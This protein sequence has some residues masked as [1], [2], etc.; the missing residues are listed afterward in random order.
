MQKNIRIT[1][2]VAIVFLLGTILFSADSYAMSRPSGYYPIKYSKI[3][4]TNTHTMDSYFGSTSNYSMG[5]K[6]WRVN[7]ELKERGYHITNTSGS[8]YDPNRNKG[9]YSDTTKA[10]VKKFQKKHGLSATGKVDKKTWDKLKIK[11]NK[12]NLIAWDHV[13]TPN[14]LINK[15]STVSDHI[16]AMIKTAQNHV[17]KTKSYG[18]G[19]SGAPGSFTDC[20][21][22]VLQCLYSAGIKPKVDVVDHTQ[23]KHQFGSKDLSNDKKLGKDTAVKNRKKGDL[24]FYAT[25]GSNTVSHVALYVGGNKIIDNWPGVGITK[26]S[27]NIRGDHIVKCK[28]IFW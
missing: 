7:K 2:L 21:G 27:E 1:L 18:Y 5:V 8:S 14:L 19:C 20:S 25:K 15:K 17:G 16:D 3:T 12:G 28:R 9:V 4:F 13:Y 11:N 24:L 26:R 23:R 10:A 22:L 6:V